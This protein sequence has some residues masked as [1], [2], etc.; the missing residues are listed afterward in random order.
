MRGLSNAPA[1]DFSPRWQTSQPA[2]PPRAGCAARI[3]EK[4][5]RPA[6]NAARL[7]CVE[8]PP[9]PDSPR[10]RAYPAVVGPLQ[11]SRSAGDTAPTPIRFAQHACARAP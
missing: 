2:K 7:A 6:F 10:T 9:T 4:G 8:I 1:P 3:A 11:A 5:P